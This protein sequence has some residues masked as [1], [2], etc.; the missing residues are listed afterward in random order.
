MVM[1]TVVSLE[2]VTFCVVV[3][4]PYVPLTVP[5]SNHAVVANSLALTVPLSVAE[6]DVTLVAELVATVGGEDE[7]S[8]IYY[9]NRIAIRICHIDMVCR[10]IDSHAIGITP[11]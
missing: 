8:S 1:L 10:G 4:L 3:L 9:T 5:Y 6:F 7:E 2:P 11:N